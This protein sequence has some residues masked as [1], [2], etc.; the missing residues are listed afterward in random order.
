[1][2]HEIAAAKG[3]DEWQEHSL[4]VPMKLALV[5]SEVSEALEA[6]RVGDEEN[7]REELA[8][9]IIRVLHLASHLEIDID[10]AVRSKI[11]INRGRSY[12]HGSKKY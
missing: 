2:I 6:H 4:F 1:M 12:K 9:I 7:L 11:E 8:D 10:A 3:F 5:H